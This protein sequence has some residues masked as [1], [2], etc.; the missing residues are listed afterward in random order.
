[1]TETKTPEEVAT[2]FDVEAWLVDA[3]LPEESADV[4]KRPDVISE[5]TRVKVRLKEA[6]AINSAERTS[7]DKS[8]IGFL[9]AEYTQLLEKFAASRLTVYVRAIT[10]ERLWDLRKEHDEAVKDV[11]SKDEQN[12]LFGYVLLAAAIVAMRAEGSERKPVTLTPEQVRKFEQAI[13]A[14]QM[15]A[16]LTARQRAQNSVPTVDADFLSRLSG[17]EAGQE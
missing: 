4:F 5:L 13:G 3:H 16:I 7:A 6:S 14:V 9:E 15:P 17:A 2:D 10:Q 12:R 11:E 8:E 1:M